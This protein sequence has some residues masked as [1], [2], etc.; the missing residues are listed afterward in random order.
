MPIFLS[1]L[2]LSWM[3]SSTGKASRPLSKLY[4]GET[5]LAEVNSRRAA[6]G[7]APYNYNASL[8]ASAQAHSDYQ[9]SIGQVTHTGSGGTRPADRARAAG[10]GDGA[11]VFVTENIYGGQNSSPSGAVDWWIADGGWHLEG[12][13]STTY[14]DAGA[15]IASSGGMVY[16]TLDAGYVAGNVSSSQGSSSSGGSSTSATSAP[17]YKPMS[18]ATASSDGSIIHNV[19]TGQ[20]LWTI[21]AKYKISLD[22][23]LK[24]NNLNQNSFVHPGD[25]IIIQPSNTPGG[26]VPTEQTPASGEAV[27]TQTEVVQPSAT[28]PIEI[29]IPKSDNA[30]T[31]DN[32]MLD[33]LRGVAALIIG[34]VALSAILIISF[35][36]KFD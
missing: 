5:L 11:Q 16:Y 10:Y 4:Q 28:P 7:L 29:A 2:A 33:P 17:A 12:V 19:E 9:A 32:G 27:A 8:M 20:T 6:N 30:E 34:I 15:G 18:L 22:T 36:R 1:V 3:P 25:K 26:A 21:A 14:Q 13:L 31:S 23:L 35:S 24:L